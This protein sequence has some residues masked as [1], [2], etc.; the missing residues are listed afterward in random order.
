MYIFRYLDKK[1]WWKLSEFIYLFIFA[2]YMTVASCSDTSEILLVSETYQYPLFHLL[3]YFHL[4]QSWIYLPL[5]LFQ[6][7]LF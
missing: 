3:M 2:F 4:C 1:S 7:A 5:N 6:L